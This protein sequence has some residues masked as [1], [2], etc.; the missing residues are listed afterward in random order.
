MKKFSKITILSLILVLIFSN[1]VLATNVAVDGLDKNL[2]IEINNARSYVASKSLQE[3][4]L[5]TT[6]NG[7]T[8]IVKNDEV[9]FEFTLGS[10]RV[11]VNGLDL[12]LDAKPYKND[13]DIYLP[14]RFILET[15]N[16]KIGWDAEAQKIKVEKLQDITFPITIVDGDNTYVVEKEAKT[17]VSMAPG[18]TEKLFALGVGDR[19][20]GRTQ[21]C[22]YPEEVK[23]I[24]SIGT[25]YEPNLETILDINPDL[26]IC[27]THFKDEVIAKLNEAGIKVI[28]KSTAKDIEGVYDYMLK[29]GAIVNKNYEA[30][31]LVSSLRAKVD[32]VKYVLKDLKE[33]DKPKVYYVVGTGQWGEYTA[34]KDTFISELISLAG[35]KNVADDITGWKYS[36]E[37]LIDHNPDIIIGSQ[38][39]ID[40]MVNGENYQALSAI[41][42]KKYKIVNEDIFVRAAP[43]AIDEGLKILVET[44][45]KYKVKELGF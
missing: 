21:Y 43:R 5:T 18:V 35:G 45:H 30:R 4:G 25:L 6:E 31:A 20:K 36:L 27:E 42:N 34:G 23:N 11:K 2:N 37:K 7:N 9:V 28:A 17:I 19:I 22:N 38:F 32:R 44:F 29:L 24:P 39:N 10:N 8:V 3:F 13:K 40:T 41:K 15:L 1:L 14:L 26:V 33:S 12:T 16:Y